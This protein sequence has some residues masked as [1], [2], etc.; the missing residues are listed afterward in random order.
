MPAADGEDGEDGIVARMRGEAE[1]G[2]KKCKNIGVTVV[3]AGDTS[4]LEKTLWKRIYSFVESSARQ[5][6][7]AHS[8][9]EQKKKNTYK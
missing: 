7:D 9:N 8:T 3:G 5:K 6:V 2:G 4:T 1:I